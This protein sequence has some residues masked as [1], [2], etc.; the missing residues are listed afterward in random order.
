MGGYEEEG[1]EEMKKRNGAEMR[2]EEWSGDERGE[3][4]E[5]RGRRVKRRDKR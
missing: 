2:E 5:Q 3:G 4:G 1:R